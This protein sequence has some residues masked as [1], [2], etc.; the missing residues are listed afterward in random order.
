MLTRDRVT[1]DVIIIF[2][3][4]YLSK[5]SPQYCTA[6]MYIRIEQV[7]LFSLFELFDNNVK[8]GLVR[9]NTKDTL[10]VQPFFLCY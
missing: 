9:S 3:T 2:F 10:R 5:V 1:R 6:N 8:R 7:H 4:M